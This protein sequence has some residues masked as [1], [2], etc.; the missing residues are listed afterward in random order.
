MG[1]KLS[2][3]AVRVG[4]NEMNGQ[5]KTVRVRGK[6]SF[7]IH[8]PWWNMRKQDQEGQQKCLYRRVQVH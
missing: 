5:V 3:A 8:D 7:H 6:F 2:G 1:R 4:G